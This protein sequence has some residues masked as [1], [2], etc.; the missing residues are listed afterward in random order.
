[1]EPDIATALATIL[2]V[3]VGSAQVV[4]LVAQ[5]AVLRA[6]RRQH[7][8]QLIDAYRRWWSECRQDWGILV[9]LGK[10]LGEY[11]QVANEK[12]IR[13]LRAKCVERRGYGPTVW[14]HDSVRAVTRI[15]SD[16]CLR[17]MQGHL[18]PSD[19][20]P[21]F[22]TELLRHAR[23]LRVILD[24]SYPHG[25]NYSN[26]ELEIMARA[27]VEFNIKRKNRLFLL[28]KTIQEFSESRYRRCHQGVRSEI[29]GWLNYHD[30]IRRRCLILIDL[31]WSE[32]A[33]LEDLPAYDLWRAAESKKHSGSL[34]RARLKQECLRLNGLRGKSIARK[35]VGFLRH[36][37]YRRF[38]RRAG[39]K[40][41]R[42]EERDPKWCGYLIRESKR[43]VS[44]ASPKP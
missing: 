36:S 17:V 25:N 10:D 24:S 42:L 30:G 23:A 4:V 14:A 3:V 32:A 13:D 22:G 18:S 11:Y 20:Y 16:A 21:I 44:G 8:L 1:M 5:L 7:R 15:L 26:V 37:E 28:N 39:I 12:T 31:L 43:K 29:Q 19:V 9:F 34:N 27:A 40:L 35:L 6:E 38:G 41:R 2:L 33:R